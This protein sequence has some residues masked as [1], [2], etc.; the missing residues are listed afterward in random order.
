MLIAKRTIKLHL[1]VDYFKW[2]SFLHQDDRFSGRYNVF[3]PDVVWRLRPSNSFGYKRELGVDL[4]QVADF[5]G[6]V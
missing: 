1:H 4:G 3:E 6:L 5:L 2:M